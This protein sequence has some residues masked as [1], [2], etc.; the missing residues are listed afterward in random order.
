MRYANARPAPDDVKLG[1]SFH[2]QHPSA[3]TSYRLSEDHTGFNVYHTGTREAPVSNARADITRRCDGLVRG[4]G[5]EAQATCNGTFT[6]RNPSASVAAPD[7]E[8]RRLRHIDQ[9][10][11]RVLEL[12]DERPNDTM[13]IRELAAVACLSTFHFA[14][15]FKRNLGVP[16][17]RY[18]AQRRLDIAKLRVAGGDEPLVQ[19]AFAAGYSSQSSFTRAFRKATGTTPGDFRRSG[20]LVFAD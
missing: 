8:I 16:P 4:E 10:L 14:R 19:I 11:R 18:L 13:E 20:R 2:A 15:M 7:D 9:R 1:H 17:H 12:I 5:A 3:A 6:Y